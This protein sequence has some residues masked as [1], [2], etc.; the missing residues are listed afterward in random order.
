MMKKSLNCKGLSLVEVVMSALVLTIV[1]AAFYA[2]YINAYNMMILAFHKTVAIHWAQAEIESTRAGI[3][4]QSQPNV[5]TI[6]K[7]GTRPA[8]SISNLGAM[9]IV[10]VTASWTE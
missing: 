6:H 8:A 2:V 1:L 7:G 4:S 10:T 9:Q 5:L 3:A